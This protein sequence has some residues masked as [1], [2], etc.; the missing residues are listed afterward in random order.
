MR[1]KGHD[2]TE[3]MSL[4]SLPIVDN[5]SENEE[6]MRSYLRGVLWSETTKVAGDLREFLAVLEKEAEE[7]NYF[8]PLWR[9]LREIKSDGT[10]IQAAILLISAMWT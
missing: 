7:I 3:L 6:K 2:Y 4:W 5:D 9:G 1:F 10:L 8:A